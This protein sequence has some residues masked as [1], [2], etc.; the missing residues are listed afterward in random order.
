[1]NNRGFIIPFDLTTSLDGLEGG[2]LAAVLGA[3]YAKAH[4]LTSY[5]LP[6]KYALLS[7][8]VDGI[9]YESSRMCAN[10]P[11]TSTE[12]VRRF[13]AKRTNETD[14]KRHETLETH[15][16]QLTNELTNELT[17]D[18][19]TREVSHHLIHETA[20]KL[21]IP[22]DFADYFEG[23]MVKLDWR[24]M[25]QDGRTFAVSDMNVAQIMR[26]WW[27]H[28]NRKNP[29]RASGGMEPAADVLPSVTEGDMIS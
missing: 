4:G 11:L 17:S 3:A 14:M 19:R 7:S 25:G 24:T 26:N 10:P 21:G 28:E 1:M 27:A 16:T 20:R 13:R 12:R 9:A 18:T 22:T 15:E 29:A 6:K 23:E 8:L 5:T 2:A